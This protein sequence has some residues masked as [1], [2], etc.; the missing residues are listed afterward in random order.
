M[1]LFGG[2]ELSGGETIEFQSGPCASGSREE[3]FEL[4]RADAAI[5]QIERKTAS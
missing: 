1:R 4:E 5:E 3:V 2:V